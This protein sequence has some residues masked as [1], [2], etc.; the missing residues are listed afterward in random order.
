[1][2]IFVRDALY[3]LSYRGTI[4]KR[5]TG[6]CPTSNFCSP[7]CPVAQTNLIPHPLRYCMIANIMRFVKKKR[8]KNPNEKPLKIPLDF[9][10]TL[11]D[12]LQVPPE[13]KKKKKKKR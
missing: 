3:P 9:E 12:I 5:A 13:Q 4:K 8:E 10:E 6:V 1:M 7:Q 2:D 11:K